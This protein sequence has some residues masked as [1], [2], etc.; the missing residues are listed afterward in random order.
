M[1]FCDIVSVLGCRVLAQPGGEL[2]V[3]TLE[4]VKTALVQIWFNNCS[5]G[6]GLARDGYN[7]IIS[8]IIISN[9]RTR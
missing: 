3:Y 8:I 7:I 1:Q 4:R 6:H 9:A 2:A 5:I